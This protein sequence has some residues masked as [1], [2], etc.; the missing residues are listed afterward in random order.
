MAEM[1]AR[2]PRSAV[3]EPV[4]ARAVGGGRRPG[5]GPR[6]PHGPA[7]WCGSGQL[8]VAAALAQPAPSAG[9]AP[10]ARGGGRWR[11]PRTV[12][13]GDAA[14]AGPGRGGHAVVVGGGLAGLRRPR[15]LAAHFARVTLVERDRLPRPGRTGAR[16]C[17][18]PAHVHNLLARGRRA[19][20][21]LFPGLDAELRRRGAGRR[22]D[23][24]RPVV[25]LRGLEAPLP[26]RHRRPHVHPPAAGVGG[27]PAPPRRRGRAGHRSSRATR[28][29]AWCGAAPGGT[30]P[31]WPASGSPRTAVGR[32]RRRRPG[33]G[34]AAG[35]AGADT[36][37]W[38]ADLVVDAS[39]RDS[40]AP[41]WL[42]ALGYARAPEDD[43]E[44]VPGLRHRLYARRAGAAA[45]WRR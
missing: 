18:R 8:G 27:A 39:G 16:A 20:E 7:R 4:R 29:R 33:P 24:G 38:A 14:G 32:R 3:G 25:L 34:A 42:A 1:T 43:G 45:D 28:R 10:V 40:R 23:G 21:G 5:D 37:R 11:R 41:E 6:Q 9:A 22:L 17:H 35:E 12:P 15:V 30:A 36:W 13:R 44:L 31:P 19:L 2:R 26:L